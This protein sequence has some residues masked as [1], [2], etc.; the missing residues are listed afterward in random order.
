MG[1]INRVFVHIDAYVESGDGRHLDVLADVIGEA[2]KG[3][4]RG[5]VDNDMEDEALV[6]RIDAADAVLKDLSKTD[7]R[8][9]EA[10]KKRLKEATIE[11]MAC[12]RSVLPLTEPDRPWVTLDPRETLF[13]DDDQYAFAIYDTL[14][15][16]VAAL[17]PEL[18]Q[19][20]C[21]VAWEPDDDDGLG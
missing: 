1:D 16:Q 15:D 11:A 18:E 14:A 10:L 3:A 20:A 6:A 2:I 12:R 7:E 9:L 19:I 21:E 5:Y 8:D 4:K 17:L 13:N